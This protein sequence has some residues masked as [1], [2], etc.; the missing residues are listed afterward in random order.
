MAGAGWCDRRSW[1]WRGHAAAERG[2]AGLSADRGALATQVGVKPKRVELLLGLGA[3]VHLDQVD[4]DGHGV[5]DHLVRE[6]DVE[7]R[8]DV[9]VS[10]AQLLQKLTAGFD[11]TL[12]PSERFILTN[13]F[14]LNDAPVLTRVE[15]GGLMSMSRE[16]VR[17]AEVNALRRLHRMLTTKTSGARRS[18]M[19]RR[20]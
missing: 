8:P 13:H 11:D 12:N 17:L 10:R 3:A 2:W 19:E 14:G 9:A 1:V 18:P 16:R 15:I 5:L 6:D 4:A 7:T 20:G